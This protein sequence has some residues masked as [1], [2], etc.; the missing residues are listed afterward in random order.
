VSARASS[1]S[2]SAEV[3]APVKRATVLPGAG[4]SALLEVELA[5]ALTADQAPLLAKQLLTL[6]KY[7]AQV[8]TT[9]TPLDEPVDSEEPM[10]AQEGVV[11]LNLSDD[12]IL[13]DLDDQDEKEKTPASHA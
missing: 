7:V 13:R 10:E 3:P 9:V 4:T 1:T 2:S 12:D 11:P 8:D 6:K 5:R